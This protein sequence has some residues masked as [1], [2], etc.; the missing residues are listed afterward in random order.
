PALTDHLLELAKEI[1][2]ELRPGFACGNGNLDTNSGLETESATRR[3][4]DREREPLFASHPQ[5]V[6]QAANRNR[7]ANIDLVVLQWAHID[8]EVSTAEHLSKREA[9][10]RVP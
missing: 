9:L 10:M 8:E 7:I 3:E 1:L 6:L 5:T 2:R 4:H